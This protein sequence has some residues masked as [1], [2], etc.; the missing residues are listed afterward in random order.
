MRPSSTV[1]TC[2]LLGNDRFVV[3]A[4]GKGSFSAGSGN[5][6]EF[7]PRFLTSLCRSWNLRPF[8]PWRG[9]G[10]VRDNSQLVG[11]RNQG[12]DQS[13]GIS[14]S[15]PNSPDHALWFTAIRASE[16]FRGR[17]ALSALSGPLPRSAITH[18]SARN[19]RHDAPR[20][21]I[22]PRCQS[23]K[24]PASTS[25]RALNSPSETDPNFRWRSGRPKGG[26][27]QVLHTLRAGS[28]SKRRGTV[29]LPRSASR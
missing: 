14:D 1:S 11:I 9:H 13:R 20:G 21:P 2:R 10:R 28:P 3:N 24:R 12:E 18:A 6:K 17:V 22:R 16:R 8:V 19:A 4:I 23:T 25:R 27:G 15:P 29:S 26:E 7:S 5:R